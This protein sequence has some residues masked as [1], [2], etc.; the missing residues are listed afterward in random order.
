M[1]RKEK[2]RKTNWRITLTT[3]HSPFK[4]PTNQTKQIRNEKRRSRKTATRSELLW[5]TGKSPGDSVP[6]ISFWLFAIPTLLFNVFAASPQACY[7]AREIK[8][9]D[10]GFNHY[11]IAYTKKGGLV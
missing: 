8:M 11:H 7:G 10:G 9:A 3:L 5:S 6:Y 2:N 4:Y 1:G